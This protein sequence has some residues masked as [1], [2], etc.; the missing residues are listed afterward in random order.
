[1]RPLKSNW[2]AAH[3]K[4]YF[5]PFKLNRISHYYQWDRYISVLRVVS[6]YF[7]FS[8]K[9]S[10]NILLANS[11]DPHQMPH[12]VPSDLGLHCLPMSHKKEARLL[13]VN[14]KHN[15]ID[16]IVSLFV[17]KIE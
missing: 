17:Y 12:S 8:F 3:I 16:H 1:M 15:Y 7:T 13:W 4:K 2:V 10:L 9:F 6:R 5:N 14:M 11:G